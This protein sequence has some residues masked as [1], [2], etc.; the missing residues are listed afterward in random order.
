MPHHIRVIRI[1]AEKHSVVKDLQQRTLH[2]LVPVSLY[3]LLE[4][5]HDIVLP[6]RK[7]SIGSF[8][9]ESDLAF[10]I[11]HFIRRLGN[12]FTVDGHFRNKVRINVS[13]IQQIH[14]A[15]AIRQKAVPPVIRQH[16]HILIHRT[17]AQRLPGNGGGGNVAF[18]LLDG[19]A[20][21]L[22]VVHAIFVVEDILIHECITG[23]FIEAG[24]H[25]GLLAACGDRV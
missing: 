16:I 8:I 1:A 21:I 18:H 19:G 9:E 12:R 6:V 11:V 15:A 10:R 25:D 13:D 2:D 22:Q 24:E 23:R 7:R 4:L 3:G 14:E 20:V 5:D 17:T